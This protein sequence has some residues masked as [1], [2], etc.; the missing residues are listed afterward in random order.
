M[1]VDRGAVAQLPGLTVLE[2]GWLSSNNTVLHGEPGEGAV[3]VDSGHVV[4]AEQTVAL[5]THALRGE[6][7]RQLVNTHLHSDHCG[8]NAAL[9][10]TVD[11]PT[12]VPASQFDA[13]RNWDADALSHRPTGQRCERFRVDAALQPGSTLTVAGR[14][15]QVLA[16][17]GHDPHSVILFEPARGVLIS[18]D[19]LWENGFGVVFPELEGESGFDEA[20]A[21]F[22]LIERLPVRVVVPGHGPVFD[23]VAGA[24]QRA[25]SR[26]AAHR[27][28]P[29]RHARHAAKVLIKYHLMEEREQ[30]HADLIAW[31]LATPLMASI[32]A[33][34]SVA[35]PLAAWCDQLVG[36]LLQSGALRREGD[37]VLDAG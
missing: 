21:V 1:S 37:R 27:A 3:L 4:H 10:R 25:R 31:A 34:A 14:L 22:D 7:L 12:W 36:E 17:P 32:Q 23:D 11:L 29:E 35:G 26:L 8:G 9:Q 5:V 30:A 19:A 13:A 20:A 28:A 18:A 24:L 6:P 16:A 15:W 33:V 2:R